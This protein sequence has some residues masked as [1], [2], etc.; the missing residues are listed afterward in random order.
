VTALTDSLD[1]D[2]EMQPNEFREPVKPRRCRKHVW[3]NKTTRYR[4]QPIGEPE[5]ITTCIRCGRLQDLALSR[6]GKSSRRLG[7]VDWPPPNGAYHWEWCKR[8][9]TRGMNAKCDCGGPEAKAR[10]EVR[11]IPSDPVD[12]CEIGRR[13]MDP[14]DGLLLAAVL[15]YMGG[16]WKSGRNAQPIADGL[17][18]G[19][20]RAASER[21]S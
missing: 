5:N 17:R 16:V 14:K 2:S 3:G 12:E 4:M 9:N 6:R 21:K 1:S 15:L 19:I 20:R 11:D 7:S 18:D 13:I 8:V 10:A